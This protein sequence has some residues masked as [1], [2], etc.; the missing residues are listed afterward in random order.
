MISLKRPAASPS[1]GKSTLHDV[2]ER[3]DHPMVSGF[4]E[5]WEAKRGARAM[6][7]RGDFEIEDLA[8][9]FG[10]VIIMDIID[11]GANFRY[12]LVGTTI[13]KFLNRDYTGRT[14]LECNYSGAQGK[15]LDTFR[16]PI[17]E[18]G[19]VFRDGHVAWAAD[20]TWRNYQSVHC[21]VAA[22]GSEPA[23]TI[24]VLYFGNDP[25]TGPNGSRW[26]S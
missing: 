6:P 8:P 9:W 25:V 10:H 18:G 24:G 21:P 17:T 4:A 5:I 19:P 11:G 7:D 15:I 23:M 2:V 3:C 16:R 22:G 12:R 1:L 14:V 13:T 20:K 26:K